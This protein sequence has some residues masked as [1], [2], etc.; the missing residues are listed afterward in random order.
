MTCNQARRICS[1]CGQ[2]NRDIIFFV[3][4]KQVP[5]VRNPNIIF[6]RQYRPAAVPNPG[7]E[8]IEGRKPVPK[9]RK[10]GRSDIFLFY[11]K[12]CCG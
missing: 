2:L 10:N 4:F 6:F 5:N 1:N 12:A 8:N 11:H 7:T 9:G 3:L